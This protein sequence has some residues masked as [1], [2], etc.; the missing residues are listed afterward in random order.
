MASE[1]F[2]EQVE[3][4]QQL[5]WLIWSL[6]EARIRSVPD[7]AL[8]N[9]LERGLQKTVRGSAL[10][11]IERRLGF[12]SGTKRHSLVAVLGRLN[13]RHA[14]AGPAAQEVDR[15]LRR[16]LWQ[17]AGKSARDLALDCA[18]SQ[19]LQRRLGAWRFFG[20]HELDGTARALLAERAPQESHK[21]FFYLVANDAELINQVG[22]KAVLTALDEFYWCG[23]ALQTYLTAGRSP[24]Q[25]ASSYPG[26]T[27]FA[28]R[29]A[30]RF[31]LI[32]LAAKLFNDNRSTSS[33]VSAAIQCFGSLQASNEL[34]ETQIAGRK[35]LEK[36]PGQIS[37]SLRLDNVLAELDRN[38]LELDP[39]ST[40]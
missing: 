38:P 23:R 15:L 12:W 16:L 36:A 33:V 18:G 17:V 13:R 28:I 3:Q 35:L 27:I 30:E 10:K 24:G 5:D 8:L 21:Y 25:L 7:R 6:R 9:A 11:E 1:S 22:L 14:K 40:D 37:D 34:A 29:R 19:R 26:E 4:S 20:H 32:P 39:I 31:D 2:A